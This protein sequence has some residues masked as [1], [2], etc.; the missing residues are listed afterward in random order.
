[1]A[2]DSFNCV[3]LTN[4]I[5]VEGRV[6]GGNGMEQNLYVF[7][8][9]FIKYCIPFFTA[10]VYELHSESYLIFSLCFKDFILFLFVVVGEVFF[11]I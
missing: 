2:P 4:L 6:N 10:L 7:A 9:L 1:M 5:V 11:T 8:I 3:F